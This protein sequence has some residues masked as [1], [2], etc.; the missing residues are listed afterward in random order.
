MKSQQNWEVL[1]QRTLSWRSVAVGLVATL[2]VLSISAVSIFGAAEGQEEDDSIGLPAQLGDGAGFRVFDFNSMEDR[3]AYI[4]CVSHV[5][6]DSDDP[7]QLLPGSETCFKEE[8]SAA[9]FALRGHAGVSGQQSGIVT[10]NPMRPRINF[11]I[12]IHYDYFNFRGPSLTLTGRDCLGGGITLT[13]GRWDNRINST[14]NGCSAIEH[15]G[16]SRPYVFQG[17][18]E[19]T[20]GSGG[21]LRWL[22]NQV[23]GI[24]YKAQL[25]PPPPPTTPP[26]QSPP[27]PQPVSNQN[28]TVNVVA[29]EVT[30]GLQNWQNDVRLVKNR[31]TVVRVFL[32]KTSSS[33]NRTTEI[34]ADLI[35]TKVVGD[36]NIRLGT[37]GAINPNGR[38]NVEYNIAS[39]RGDID[40]SLNFVLPKDWTNLNSNEKLRL[41]LSIKSTVTNNCSSTSDAQQTSVVGNCSVEV[42][43]EEVPTQTFVV[44]PIAVAIPDDEEPI[45]GNTV[46]CSV[47]SVLDDEFEKL[48]FCQ[49]EEQRGR[50]FSNMPFSNLNFIH[51]HEG[52]LIVSDSSS[53]DNILNQLSALRVQ[54]E[55]SYNYIGIIPCRW[56]IEFDD[57]I[58][59]PGVA[60]SDYGVA[61]W[62]AVATNGEDNH[63]ENVCSENVDFSGY[64]R[65]TGVHEVGHLLGESHP[66]N[67]GSIT[68]GFTGPCGE[69][70]SVNSNYTYFDSINEMQRPL[71]GSIENNMA[72]IWGFDTR[73]FALRNGGVSSLP[74]TLI[75][76]NP[77]Q[78]FSLMSYCDAGITSNQVRWMDEFHHSRIIDRAKNSNTSLRTNTPPPFNTASN[79]SEIITGIIEISSTGNPSGVDLNP[80]QARTNIAEISQSGDYTLDLLDRT[81]NVLRSL[82]FDASVLPRNCA[83]AS[84]SSASEV[85][86]ALFAIVLN[87]PP[88]YL[89]LRFSKSGT[90]FASLQRSSTPPNLVVIGPQQGQRF[91]SNDSIPLVWS[92]IDAEDD[93]VKYTVFYSTDSGA[94]YTTI[95]N[96]AETAN[97]TFDA[98]NLKG[99]NSAR[100]GISATDGLRAVFIETDVFAVEQHSPNV[101]IASPGSGTVVVERQNFVLSASGYDIEDGTLPYGAFKWRSS[102]DGNLGVGRYVVLSAADLTPGEHEITV[103][104]S[105]QSGAEATASTNVV[106]S[107][108]EIVP[109]AIDDSVSVGLDT[110]TYIDVV[111]NDLN[112]DADFARRSLSITE[113]PELGTAEVAVSP[114]GIRSITYIA[115]TSGIDSIKYRI[116][117]DLDRCSEAEV[118]I[119]VAI[120][121]CTIVGTEGDD[122]LVG[123]SGDDVICGMGG[124]DTIDGRRGNDIL[125]G[126]L[127][128]DT[129]Y[130]GDGEDHINGGHG[131]DLILG[132][133][134]ND[135]LHGRLGNDKIYGGGGDD[136]VAGGDGDDELYGEADD[137]VLEGNAG[138]DKIHGGRGDDIIRGGIG[139]DTIRGNAGA[140]T[141]YPGGGSDTLLGT[142]TEDIVIN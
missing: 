36:S 84:C 108:Y 61:T 33:S 140:D 127:G 9:D 120:D 94:T 65:N 56:S 60:N 117:D 91:S 73:L 85:K 35:G 43:F 79:V 25:P 101:E 103:T 66:V 10:V 57:E 98:S 99:S 42:S 92:G 124:N 7:S 126:G 100:F 76:S 80:I 62:T 113:A 70:S 102:K 109:V 68:A 52:S 31:P 20:Y 32:E 128:D 39:N 21:N 17:I 106:I 90:Q 3:G 53:P 110:P 5:R 45:G 119:N 13:G 40:K 49:I 112:I 97:A 37:K 8:S 34:L 93:V 105:D 132:H 41:T 58:R 12:G 69:E 137:D 133:R 88:D 2:V 54:D 135:I 28:V 63:E 121:N 130:G 123:T 23:S 27:P 129:I 96:N 142:S 38:V 59:S 1:S 24:L 77:R 64:R 11:I 26:T 50:I 75:V 139:D 83:P 78:V 82:K 136:I 14:L 30:Q 95:L 104:A 86:K 125:Y 89:T 115:F 51:Y 111:S 141:I 19:T 134:G 22:P 131:N 55:S 44:V 81:G 72:E 116:C 6:Q 4:H 47:E 67:M 48:S 122:T 114:K 74:D 18:K 107:L 118:T 15:Y 138:S 71:L 87:N 16:I 46:N 29:I